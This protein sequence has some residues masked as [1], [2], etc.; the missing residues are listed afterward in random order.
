M[1]QSDSSLQLRTG[2]LLFLQ[3]GN[4]YFKLEGE[5]PIAYMLSDNDIVYF[6]E[7]RYFRQDEVVPV[8]FERPKIGCIGWCNHDTVLSAKLWV[9]GQMGFPVSRVDV[10]KRKVSL[11]N[12]EWQQ[13]PDEIFVS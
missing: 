12:D 13:K 4:E 3:S 10:K 9:Q 5:V 11:K 6:L 2:A 8:Y 7:D 1:F